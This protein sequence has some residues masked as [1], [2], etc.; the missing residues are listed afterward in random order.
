MAYKHTA[1]KIHTYKIVICK[2]ERKKS[3]G[4]PRHRR[5]KIIK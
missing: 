2:P 4:T 5:R 3:L 1:C